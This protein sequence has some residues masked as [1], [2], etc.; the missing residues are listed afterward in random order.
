MSRQK[1]TEEDFEFF[2][3]EFLKWL[4]FFGIKHYRP[5]FYHVR[6]KDALASFSLDEYG[7]TIGI[8][9]STD[10]G[11][12]KPTRKLLSKCAFH[13]AGDIFMQP[14]RDYMRGDPEELMGQVHRVVRTL[15]NIIFEREWKD[16]E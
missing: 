12:D 13:E 2:K 8:R 4:E 3:V 16:E 5:Y 1:T 6:I 15:E 11:D 14:C 7:G 10:W 9:L